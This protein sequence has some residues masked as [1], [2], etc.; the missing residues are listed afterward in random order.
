VLWWHMLSIWNLRREYDRSWVTIV[1]PPALGLIAWISS[2][3][4]VPLIAEWS[5]GSCNTV[6]YGQ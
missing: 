6:T 4:I 5:S 3:G 2:N 1:Q